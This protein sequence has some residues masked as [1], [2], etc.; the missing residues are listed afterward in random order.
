[1]IE[2]ARSI[3]AGVRIDADV[4]VVGG[5]AAGLAV[6]LELDGSLDVCV[7]EAGGYAPDRAT[8]SLLAGEG[9]YTGGALDESRVVGL[10]GTTRVWSGW[11]RPL[12][13]AAFHARTDLIPDGWPFAAEELAPF[14]DR[15]QILCGLGPAAYELEDWRSPRSVLPLPRDLVRTRLYQMSARRFGRDY[16]GTLQASSRTRVLTHAVCTGIETELDGRHVSAL[17][18]ATLAGNSFRVRARYFVLATGGIE[19]ARLLLLSGEGRR[20]AIGDDHGQLGRFFMEHPYVTAG[21]LQPPRPVRPSGSALGFYYPHRAFREGHEGMVRGVFTPAPE[22][23]YPEGLLMSA[24]FPLPSWESHPATA[25]RGGQALRRLAAARRRGVWPRGGVRDMTEAARDPLGT[26]SALYQRLLRPRLGETPVVS[27]GVRLFCESHPRASQR[28]SLT[29]R[30][31]R[32]GRRRARL[33]WEP[34]ERQL[35]S[36][37]RGYL[38]LA[39]A[40]SAAGVGRLEWSLDEADVTLEAGRHHMGATRMHTDPRRGVVDADC[41]VHGT[42][43]LF[44]AG[45]SVFPTGGFANPTLTIVALAARLARR[46]SGLAPSA[47]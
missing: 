40:M 41:R 24:F 11:C 26:A 33:D 18:C 23:I 29:A 1:M 10:G 21:R 31:D 27:V 3:S 14:Y 34:S 16:A 17:R 8:Q 38:L 2:D 12:E 4:C 36:M 7:L 32:L 28:V 9:S 25:S 6:A 39:E 44:V 13:R 20:T 37:E 42:D 19:N 47:V 5:G 46:L 22:R 15:A 43:N 35:H 45:S 30:R